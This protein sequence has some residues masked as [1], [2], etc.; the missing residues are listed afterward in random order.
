MITVA[1]MINGK[2]IFARSATNISEHPDDTDM[3]QAYKLDYP[4]GF[5]SHIPD[6]GFVP[7]VKK[8]LDTIEE[9]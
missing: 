9:T 7:L 2:T 3:P 6:E 8:M 5:I 4:G 1:V